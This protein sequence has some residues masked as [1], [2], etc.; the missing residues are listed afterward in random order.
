MTGYEDEDNEGPGAPR[1]YH[2]SP[3]EAAGTPGPDATH[4]QQAGSAQPTQHRAYPQAGQQ[5]GQQPGYQPQPGQQPAQAS[6]PPQWAQGA[7]AHQAAH[8]GPA[9]P[10]GSPGPSGPATS[11]GAPTAFGPPPGAGYAS[12]AMGQPPYGSAYGGLAAAPPAPRRRRGLTALVVAGT[13]AASAVA[14]GVAGTVAAHRGGTNAAAAAPASST[15]VNVPASS[16][17]TSSTAIGAVAKAVL[18]SVVQVTVQS[19]GGTSLGSGIIL[20]SDGKIL[21]NNHVIADAANGQGDLTVTFNDGKTAQATI[22]GYDTNSDLAV[23]Q[24]QGVSGLPAASLGN[25]DGVQVGDT[26]IA[27]GSPDGLQSTVTSGIVSALDRTVSVSSGRGF[28]ASQV[29]YKAIQTDASINPGNSGG[30]LLN[31]SGQ[32]IGIN[33]A[34]YS[35]TNGMSQGGSV[36]LGFSIPVDQVKTLLTKLEAGAQS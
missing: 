4:V 28:N 35:P 34:I 32:V 2:P 17:T 18:P 36:G 16:Q 31:T 26:V 9:G 7:P 24:A 1:Q 6:R 25:S 19:Y 13:I 12:T 11:G 14:G 30:P 8:G 29:T 15:S 27:I 20:S 5:P 10:Y 23:I 33:S 22:V 21:T 3:A